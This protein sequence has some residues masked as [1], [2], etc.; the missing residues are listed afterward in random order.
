MAIRNAGLGVE[1]VH[2][3]VGNFGRFLE[4]NAE[5]RA[6][7]EKDPHSMNRQKLQ[8]AV[9]GFIIVKLFQSAMHGFPF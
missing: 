6:H 4:Q 2:H 3:L 7:I 1:R 9:R 5:N 8:D